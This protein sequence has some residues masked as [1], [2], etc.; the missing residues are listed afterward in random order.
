MSKLLPKGC[1][2]DK[3]YFLMTECHGSPPEG[4]SVPVNPP[5]NPILIHFRGNN[6]KVIIGP[7]GLLLKDFII[8]LQ[9]FVDSIG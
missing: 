5:V 4:F 7:K 1:L 8:L 3:E 9:F 6:N 2:C